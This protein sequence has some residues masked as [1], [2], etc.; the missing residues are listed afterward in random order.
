MLGNMSLRGKLF[1]LVGVFLVAIIGLAIFISISLKSQEKAF[2]DAQEV[3]KI[4][5]AVVGAATAGLQITSAIRGVYIDS[6]D[7]GTMKNLDKGLESMSKSM[8]QLGSKEVLPYSQGYEKFKIEPLYSAYKSDVERLSANAKAGTLTKEELITHIQDTWRPLKEALDNWRKASVKKDQES[9]KAYGETNDSIIIII[10]VLALIAV[11]FVLILSYMVV[12]SIMTSV[13]KIQTGLDSFFN[14]LNRKSTTATKI[15]L[16]T[17]DEFGIMAKDIDAN[18]TIVEKSIHKDNAFIQDVQDVMKRVGNG[19][20]SQKI[21]ANS[22]NPNLE[23]LKSNVNLALDNL[24]Q[25]FISINSVLTEYVNLD[26]RRELKIDGVEKGGVFAELLQDITHLRNAITKMLIENKQ[27]GLT[28]D[29][30]TDVLLA[31]V[32][33]LS[34]NANQAA[35]SLEE[36]AAALEEVTGN[37][38]ANTQTVIKMASLA[39]SVTVAA[40]DGQQLA[41]ETTKAMDEINKEVNAITEAIAIIDQISFQTNILSLNA[42]VEAA[43]AGEAGKGFAVVAQEV[44]NLA[45]RSSDAAN[46]IKALVSNA[47]QKANNGKN[48]ADKMISGYTEL[49]ENIAQTIELIKNVEFSSKEQLAGINQINDA[50]TLLDRQTQQNATIA[51]ETYRVTVETD[52]IAKMV[53]ANA[54]EKQFDGKES[55]KANKLTSTGN[56]NGTVMQK[57]VA[58]KPVTKAKTTVSSDSCCT[59]SAHSHTP[60]KPEIKKAIKP[61]VASA[62]DDDEWASF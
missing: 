58:S 14:F 36:T 37:I 30:S 45:N 1:T 21:V 34:K 33:V 42:A 5:G 28:L 52:N 48:I 12:N 31:N 55:V 32:D 23:I 18:I 2:H 49:N 16:D 38:S 62:K 40:N 20:F 4:R 54:E 11:I 7:Q 51:S 53:V 59:T 6:S 46:E 50:V 9:I 26:Y 29:D 13:N 41:N 19:W 24:K 35:A 17:T 61:I 25:N 60:S 47:T 27:N 43:T 56:K 3:T 39:N 15:N 57:T 8:E 22:D 44:R 10:D